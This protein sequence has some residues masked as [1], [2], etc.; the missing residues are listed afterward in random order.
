MSWIGKDFL[1]LTYTREITKKQLPSDEVLQIT[2]GIFQKKIDKAYELRINFFGDHAIT[3]KLNSQE[4]AQGKMDWRYAPIS[5]LKIEEFELPESIYQK[6]KSFM[7]K[8][9]IVFGCFDFIVTPDNEYYFLE[10]NEQGQFLWIEDVNPEI[11]LLDA[12]TDFLIAGSRDF[13]WKKSPESLSIAN[14]REQMVA[15]KEE[16]IKKHKAPATIY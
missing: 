5:E 15:I 3:A 11:K 4:H 12:F 16:A 13:T 9:G 1:R 14:Y 7:K 6:C 10:V 2:P 8:F